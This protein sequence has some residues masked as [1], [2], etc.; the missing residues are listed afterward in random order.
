MKFAYTHK[1]PEE[2]PNSWNWYPQYAKSAI[3]LDTTDRDQVEAALRALNEVNAGQAVVIPPG[4]EVQYH[5]D[6]GDRGVRYEQVHNHNGVG[7]IDNRV[8]WHNQLAE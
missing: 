3:W 1:K 8:V 4:I 2:K 6:E 5:W 7:V